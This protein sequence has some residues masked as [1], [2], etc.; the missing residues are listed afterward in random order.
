MIKIVVSTNHY[1]YMNFKCIPSLQNIEWENVEC[2]VFH[3]TRDNDVDAILE[4]SRAGD[5]VKK[6]IYINHFRRK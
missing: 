1:D 6:V 5:C 4:L 3:S 2:L